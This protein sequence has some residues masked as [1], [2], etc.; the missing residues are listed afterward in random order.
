MTSAIWPASG[1]STALPSLACSSDQYSIS[2]SSA[3]RQRLEAADRLGVGHGRDPAFGE[4]GGDRGVLGAAPETEQ[5]EPR[6]QDH[7]RRRVELALALAEARVVAGEIGVVI[8]DEPL[9]RLRAP[10]RRSRRAG[11]LRAPARS[12]GSSWCGSC[13]R[14]WRPRPGRSARS[15]APL[16][17][18]QHRRARRGNRARSA[19][20]GPA[21]PDRAAR[22]RR[23]GSARPRR[24]RRCAP[25]AR[26][27]AKTR[28][29]AAR[30]PL[31]GQRDDR[32]HPL[33]GLARG[34]AEAEDAVLQQ[35]QPLDR[36]IGLEDLGRLLGRA[37][38]PA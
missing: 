8:G 31:L 35:H 37:E 14:G 23:A 12:A 16:T 19:C 29:A 28:L 24:R 6:H 7:P 36:R 21:R 38:S 2:N 13:G 17:K 3:S 32:D 4:I 26:A 5:P 18:L 22:R 10:R 9:D 27:A 34:V 33:V 20:R 15:S 30:E 11:R 1:F 25:A